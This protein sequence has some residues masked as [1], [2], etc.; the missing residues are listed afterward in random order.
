MDTAVGRETES[1]VNLNYRK[2]EKGRRQQR[3][4]GKKSGAY[5]RL[6][7]TRGCGRVT[8]LRIMNHDKRSRP[9]CQA[10]GLSDKFVRDFKR[11]AVKNMVRAGIPERV[12]M[13]ISGHK[14]RSVFDRYHIVS[15]RDLQEA[16]QRLENAFPAA[17]GDHFGDHPT[18]LDSSSSVSH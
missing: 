7:A 4:R 15:D 13:Q 2:S 10:A 14:T 11:A 8:D 5:A 18:I 3:R 12:A 6:F 9:A 1:V 17:N 16:A